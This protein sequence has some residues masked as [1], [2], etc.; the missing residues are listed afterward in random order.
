MKIKFA[1]SLLL[2]FALVFGSLGFSVAVSAQQ[3]DAF[4]V[5]ETLRYE[6][7]YSK[8]LLR[9]IEI[10]DITFSVEKS[11]EGDHYVVK[12]EAKSKGTLA[13]L[14]S[15]DFDLDFQSTVDNQ[16]LQILK[17]VK[18]DEQGSRV[19][20]SEAVFDYRQKKVV[21]S[22][23]DPNDAARPPLRVASP[24]E[25]GTQ[26]LISAIYALRRLPLAVGKTF[27]LKISDSGLVYNI[28]VRVA[29]REL[30]KS[31]VGK[32]WCFRV[33]PEIFGK[34]RLIEKQGTMFLWISDDARRLP[35]R[36]QINADI[37]RI[38]IKIKKNKA[39]EDAKN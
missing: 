31:A 39:T 16:K 36:S 17:T 4:K 14:F 34:N 24:I 37:G 3:Q 9:G 35:V 13:S 7:K 30:Q 20:A 6:V 21:Y 22:E 8:A 29:A 1:R 32:I 18:R 33:E 19:R 28:P 10:G 2:F 27:T 15:R 25:S 11:A 23:T 12:S 26:D 38:E 5:G